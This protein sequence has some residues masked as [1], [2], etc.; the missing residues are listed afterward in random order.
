MSDVTIRVFT[1]DEARGIV[2]ATLASRANFRSPY[3]KNGGP[4]YTTLRYAQA[5][6]D[7]DWRWQDAGPIRMSTG[8][9]TDGLHR[10]AACA[11]SQVPLRSMV[12]EGEDWEAGAHVD[13]HKPRTLGQ[14]FVAHGITDGITKSTLCRHFLARTIAAERGCTSEH[15]KMI[16]VSRTMCLQCER[17]YRAE[18]EQVTKC[19]V[20]GTKANI[21]AAGYILFLL[22]I[23]VISMARAVEFDAAVRHRDLEPR[24]PLYH[25]LK[26]A[27]EQRLHLGHVKPMV[28]TINNLIKAWNQREDGVLLQMWKQATWTDL[29]FADGFHPKFRHDEERWA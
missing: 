15:A 10:L 17:V 6:R 20:T 23:A 27:S 18:I 19:R 2:K 5:M 13:E 29:R 22:E 28:W 25:M 16:Y 14:L 8:T 24:D 7:G 1:S 12:L 26:F 9:C 3:Q 11:I 4:D 21:N